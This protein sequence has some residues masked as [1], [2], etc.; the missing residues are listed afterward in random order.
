MKTKLI[1]V[2]QRGE[3]STR[4]KMFLRGLY[5]FGYDVEF[6]GD[7]NKLIELLSRIWFRGTVVLGGCSQDGLST[8]LRLIAQLDISNGRNLRII[9]MLGTG[10]TL[11]EWKRQNFAEVVKTKE[12]LQALLERKTAC[13]APR[14][15]LD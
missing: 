14:K 11:E 10:D 13:S 3:I 15:R 12:E 9:V 4:F 6:V 5:T 8:I 2:Q 7:G 1:Y